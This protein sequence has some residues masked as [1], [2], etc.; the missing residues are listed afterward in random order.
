MKNTEVVLDGADSGGGGSRSRNATIGTKSK[1]PA[2]RKALAH[3]ANSLK[4]SGLNDRSYHEINLKRVDEFVNKDP[5]SSPKLS[6]AGPSNIPGLH[7][8][9]DMKT[10][11]PTSSVSSS[12][13]PYEFDKML[14]PKSRFG[15]GDGSFWD[16]WVNR[17]GK[18]LESRQSGVDSEGFPVIQSG[19][20]NG[21]K[22]FYC[23]KGK[24][25]LKVKSY[26]ERRMS[27]QSQSAPVEC[28]ESNHTCL[29]PLS[30]SS[31]STPIIDEQSKR[32]FSSKGI[33]EDKL[34]S[35]TKSDEYAY[36]GSSAKSSFFEFY[37]EILAKI[38]YLHV[39]TAEGKVDERQES[40][41][42]YHSTLAD[43]IDTL[44]DCHLDSS[45]SNNLLRQPTSPRSSF[46]IGC[47]KKGLIARPSLIL[48]RKTVPELN[49]ESQMMGDSIAMEVANSIV[50]LPFLVSLNV[51][52]NGLTDSGLLAIAKALPY[53]VDL[54]ILNI[55]NNNGTNSSMQSFAEF[56]SSESSRIHTFVV[57][58]SKLDDCGFSHF[59]RAI[60]ESDNSLTYLDISHNSIGSSEAIKSA[61]TKSPL[62]IASLLD[63]PRSRLRTL[64]MGWNKV[65]AH[66][67]TEL[68]LSLHNNQMLTELD[69]SNNK[70]DTIGGS[71]LGDA[72][73][74]N[75]TLKTLNIANNNINARVCSV[76]MS[77]IK[78][79]HS[80]V[81][82][83]LSGNP[84]G[85]GGLRSYL[86]LKTVLGDG[87]IDIN[88]QHCSFLQKCKDLSACNHPDKVYSPYVKRNICSGCSN[89][90]RKNLC[91]FD[92]KHSSGSFAFDLA[93][94]YE[95]SICIDLLRIAAEIQT[96]K[97]HHFRYSEGNGLYRDLNL[98]IQLCSSSAEDEDSRSWVKKH[99][100]LTEDTKR[101][102]D[103]LQVSSLSKDSVCG[104]IEVMH[105]LKRLNI[106]DT[107][108]SMDQLFK[109]YDLENRSEVEFD[110]LIEYICLCKAE[111]RKVVNPLETKKYLAV[112]E[113]TTKP[114]IPP[115]VGTIICDFKN[116]GVHSD[117]LSKF[118][119][120]VLLQESSWQKSL[121]PM[122]LY[123]IMLGSALLGLSDAFCF[124]DLLLK[125][126]G[127]PIVCLQK[128]F[129]FISSSD[130]CRLVM[131]RAISNNTRSRFVLKSELRYLYRPVSGLPNGF[132]SLNLGNECD[133]H[134][135]RRLRAS[136]IQ[137]ASARMNFKMGDISQDGTFYGFR[138]S[139]LNGH[140]IIL[141]DDWFEKIPD[142]GRL[143]FD[144]VKMLGP[145]THE[146]PMSNQKFLRVL[147]EVFFKDEIN[148]QSE[149][150]SQLLLF[151]NE[152]DFTHIYQAEV[153]EKISNHLK[154][155]RDGIDGR[156]AHRVLVE[157]SDLD[158]MQIFDKENIDGKRT[159]TRS[160][161]AL[162]KHLSSLLY[163]F[164]VS[165]H[166]LHV[167]V[168]SGNSFMGWD[169]PR[170]VTLEG[171]EIV[172]GIRC[173]W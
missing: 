64:I 4:T 112:E 15:D 100:A 87:G 106:N 119:A 149:L 151:S 37:R 123:D 36:F 7:V 40:G 84:I 166:K 31:A 52:T 19:P 13:L 124:Y 162:R 150:Q 6:I 163:L 145:Q 75:S 152:C 148:V 113:D 115:R 70:L 117:T 160:S 161:F 169:T 78:S 94:A 68:A 20:I 118:S 58:R 85:E 125:E 111:S 48:R 173:Q 89:F 56:V 167:F 79:C 99:S 46:I 122:K 172:F 141:D 71:C 120:D 135:L 93:D 96:V 74:D 25:S 102:H 16:R 147:S 98:V 53:C 107:H 62:N 24:K 157:V 82:V 35:I 54:R 121:D 17:N 26:A 32:Q 133:V 2:P 90:V 33:E 138:N 159:S 21:F 60:S 81:S 72:L 154:E 42:K 137:D 8:Y 77:G 91:W 41:T 47:A 57:H 50:T 44:W 10:K 153:A 95:R 3:F 73:H 134:C 136:S 116:L 61:S 156:H 143:D 28:V 127:N 142:Q 171:A 144:F 164:L 88:I 5:L 45:M 132:Y 59:L 139:T 83:N 38:Q 92:W 108:I 14:G 146:T 34:P 18:H 155:L 131:D 80:L 65:R 126:L 22:T 165:D 128:I 104:K 67:A 168:P 51:A 69:I 29:S 101:Y 27:S 1:V 130:T 76:L 9:D 114:Y 105:L 170:T 49:L 140:K 11:V 39:E 86:M 63:N 129:P 158:N 12:D 103:L 97:M 110:E 55:S 66:Y 109:L 43:E 23:G 30:M